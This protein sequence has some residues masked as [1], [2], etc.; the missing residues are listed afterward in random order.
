MPTIVTLHLVENQTYPRITQRS[1]WRP[2]EFDKSDL[3]LGQRP[4]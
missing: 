1:S 2:E 3:G 4:E